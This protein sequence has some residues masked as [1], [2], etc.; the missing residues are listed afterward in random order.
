MPF[1]NDRGNMNKE[2]PDFPEIIRKVGDSLN[3]GK[4]KKPAWLLI[5]IILLLVILGYTAFYTIPPGNKGII[6][7]FGRYSGMVF[8]CFGVRIDSA[9]LSS[10]TPRLTRNLKNDRTADSLRAM[11][12][13]LF[14][15][16]S[17]PR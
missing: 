10:M 3:I 8:P 9:G 14:F 5:I 1:E 4:G 12:D 6:L 16:C 2:L 11:L 17:Q 13:F 15:L 7:R